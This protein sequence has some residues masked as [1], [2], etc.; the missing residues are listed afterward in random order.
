MKWYYCKHPLLMLV[1]FVL[2][3]RSIVGMNSPK[4]DSFAC[5]CKSIIHLLSDLKII[6]SS[7]LNNKIPAKENFRQIITALIFLNFMHIIRNYV[8]TST[9]K[10]STIIAQNSNIILIQNFKCLIHIIIY[11]TKKNILIY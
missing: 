7:T 2:K 3:E 4:C 1:V 9:T 5:V 6:F 10:W 8:A 11:L